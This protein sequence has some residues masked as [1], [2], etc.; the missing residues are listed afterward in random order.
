LKNY[1]QILLDTWKAEIKESGIQNLSD[2]FFVE[3]T[4][5]SSLLRESMRN[6]DKTS[7][8]GKI[9]VKE[10]EYV[11]KLL[12]NLIETRIEKIIKAER[13]GKPIS[14]DSLTPEEKIFHAELRRIFSQYREEMRK[15]ILGRKARTGQVAGE[16]VP[17]RTAGHKV[18]RFIKPV[19]A[20][21]GVDMKKYGPFHPEDVA[22]LPEDNAENLIRKGFAKMVEIQP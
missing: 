10:Q 21:M 13:E 4:E 6:M 8:K 1:Y 16:S 7:M 2:D 5:Y 14:I 12:N 3:I 18:V 9:M 19:P 15:V 22:S 20:I 11:E 17:K